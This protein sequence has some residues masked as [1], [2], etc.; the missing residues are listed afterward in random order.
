MPT[1]RLKLKPG[2]S[3]RTIWAAEPRKA[4]ENTTSVSTS[5]T[6]ER[7]WQIAFGLVLDTLR[8]FPEARQAVDEALLRMA[9]ERRAG[10]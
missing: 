5:E 10:R 3:Y 1:R 6:T 7:D 9:A 8:I 4:K 2:A